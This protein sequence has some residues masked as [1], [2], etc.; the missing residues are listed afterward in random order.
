M[1]SSYGQLQISPKFA[2][3]RS[4]SLFPLFSQHARLLELKTALHDAALI[5][6]RFNGRE[7]ISEPFRFEID[8]VSTN[9]IFDLGSLLGEEVTLRLQLLAPKKPN[10]N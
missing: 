10:P 1:L 5:V 9:A 8:C 2:V 4:I 7:A 6:E 3:D